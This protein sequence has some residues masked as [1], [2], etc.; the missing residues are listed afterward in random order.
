[1]TN[2]KY[3]AHTQPLFKKLRILTVF[4]ILKLKLYKF[5]Y[6]L[7]NKLI[8]KYFSDLN[9]LFR[10]QD[11][12][13][14]NTRNSDYTLPRIYHAFAE[15][16]IRYQLPYLLNSLND[17]SDTTILDTIISRACTHSEFGF[18][19]FIKNTLILQYREDCYIQNC[20]NC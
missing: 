5:F 6:R 3:N 12:H 1:M 13:P 11:D 10:L 18:S 19:L 8:P 2:S 20:Y 4:D 7:T 9:I 14:Y 17:S 16:S 15:N